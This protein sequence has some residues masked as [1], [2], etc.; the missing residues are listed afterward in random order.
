VITMHCL[1]LVGVLVC[2]VAAHAWAADG[3]PM[4]AQ[5][6]VH[7][8]RPTVFINGKPNPLPTYSPRA[9]NMAVL[10]KGTPRFYK[11]RMGAYMLP[12]P[13]VKTEGDFWAS[14]F[15]R[16][17][18]ISADP[19]YPDEALGMTL[20]AQAQAIIENDPGAYIIIRFGT[21][22]PLSWQKLHPDDMFVNEEG[23]VLQ[24]PSLASEDWHEACAKYSAAVIDY[25]E[26]RPW[27]DRIVGYANFTRL[28]GTHEP[29][30]DHWLFDH[31]PVMTKRWRAFLKEK[32]GT[33][34]KLRAAHRDAE[35]TF[36]TVPVPKDRLRG[37]VAEVSAC[38]YWQNARDNQPLRDYLELMRD[39]WHAWFRG[40]GAATEKATGG[41]RFCVY[42]ALK[43]TMLGWHHWAFFN[44]RRPWLTAYC[45]TL[46]GSGHMNVAALFDAPGFDGL[47][48]PHDYQARGI[49][50]VF[51]PEG[52]VDSIVLRGKL[53]LCEMDTR[54]YMGNDDYGRARDD[55]EFAAVTWR[56]VATGLTRGFNPYYMDLHQNW[57]DNEEI[58]KVIA[59]QVEVLKASV[60][61]PHETVPGIA[62]IIDD[63]AVLETNGA[64][65]YFNEAIMWEQKMGMARC[66]VPFRIYLLEDLA[67]DNFPRHAVYYFPNLFRVDDERLALLRKK[68]FRDGNVVVWG[69]G[70]GISDGRRIGPRS[71]ERLTGFG[72]EYLRAN[73]QRRT[74]VTDYTHP[75]TRAL[76]ADTVIGGPLAYGPLL[77][78]EGGRSLGLAWTKKGR[79]SS[80]LSV[81]TFGKGA[82]SEAEGEVGEGDWAS[83]FTAAV[84][85][86]AD[87]WRGLARYG[88]AH[89]YCEE[90][91]VLLAD[92]SVVGLHS[93]KTGPKRIA[94]PGAF[95]VTDL[96][97]GEVV[98]ESAK[99]IAFDLTAP[100]T[101]VFLLEEAR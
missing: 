20:D 42:D 55:K 32:Y 63:A 61:W 3:E 24:T 12:L 37:T 49:G 90:N 7:K 11:H 15:W 25:C 66:G 33:V 18:Q 82:R 5:V 39:L 38:L 43:Q 97:S 72:F 95:K 57:F 67:L 9:W 2:L 83:V 27:A 79:M 100:A 35:V 31:S 101:H 28:E 44:D 16:G 14:P 71:A 30:L 1:L 45:E 34:E 92:S 8:G 10:T 78:P 29:T 17:D 50:G 91:D 56:N 74:H 76:G 21:H 4:D 23:K 77:F 51:E 64:G 36:E 88:G 93:V 52:S 94:L 96:A 86:P 47:I 68:V 40:V 62:M 89:V 6:R 41:K 46:A 99:E 53:F 84:P 75:I 80:G 69:P 85:L 60:D 54:T 73:Y 81:K 26:A 70:S 59:R 22:E 48:T 98:S 19:L 58:H 87:L 13:L 65:N